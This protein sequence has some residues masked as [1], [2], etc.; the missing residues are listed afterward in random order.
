MTDVAEFATDD[1][2]VVGA[3]GTLDPHADPPLLHAETTHIVRAKP[4]GIIQ[5]GLGGALSVL[6]GASEGLLTFGN[7]V[8]L[9]E[10][11]GLVVRVDSKRI[12]VPDADRMIDEVVNAV[13][14]LPTRAISPTGAAYDRPFAKGADIDLLAYL[15]IRDGVR[16]AG[17]IEFQPPWSGFSRAHMNS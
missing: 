8:G 7:F 11:G 12:T 16:T 9:A 1:F 6:A 5:P 17:A 4:G 2:T 15:V 13:A 10:L 14:S 3:V